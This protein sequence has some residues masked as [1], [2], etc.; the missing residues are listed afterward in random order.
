MTAFMIYLLVGALWALLCKLSG[1][2]DKQLEN[3]PN[4]NNSLD[5]QLGIT[6]AIIIFWAPILVAIGLDKRKGE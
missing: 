3:D 4:L 2:I 5:T 6:V 1:E